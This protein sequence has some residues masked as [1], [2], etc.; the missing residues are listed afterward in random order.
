MLPQ[1]KVS[2]QGGFVPGMI[3][4]VVYKAKDPR[5]LGA[6]LAATRD[7][8]TYFKSGKDQTLPLVKLAYGWG[9]S[10]SG[11]FLRHFIYEGFNEGEQGG[12][13]FDAVF[14]EVGGA[15]RGSFNR[16]FGQASRDAEQHFNFFFPV[17]LFPFTDGEATEPFTNQKDSLL[18]K[19]EARKVTP[20]MFHVL[21]SSE[22]Y[23]RAGS[24]IHT[25][26]LGKFDIEPPP[27]S[28]IYLVSSTPHF[29]GAFPPARQGGNEPETNALMS[30]LSR[31]PLM[32]ALLV[33]LDEWACQGIAPPASQ[34]P[35]LANQ[36]LV[37]A[38]SSDWP[39]IPN[40]MLP[41]PALK[42]YQLD[43]S[44]EPPQLGSQYTTLVPKLDSDG[45][46]LAGV[47]HPAIAVP[48]ATYTGWNYRH[49]N[50]GAPTQLAGET[51]GMFPFAK[52]KASRNVVTDS[53]P[54][55]A[56]RYPSKEHYMGLYTAAARRL[57]QNRFLLAVDLPELIDQAS[58]YW[59]TLTKP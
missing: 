8:I 32:R 25:D 45:H 54:S 20:L 22:Y 36:T 11:R 27:T 38:T 41:P 6:A 5:V 56:E 35:K 3:Y 13:V 9:V 17:D 57:I 30:P 1:G 10:Q 51:G 40:V 55:I 24:L 7:L 15:G 28:R 31:T 26:P 2:L 4:D 14:D 19:A 50:V 42:V 33:A 43:F 29:A 21:S 59:D 18:A 48:L 53:R 58:L 12:K 47:R 44:A 23:N 39:A 49:P 52:T 16:R 34:Y 37:P 46:D